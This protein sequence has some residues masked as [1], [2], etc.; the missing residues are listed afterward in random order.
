MT[1]AFLRRG[2]PGRI[3]SDQG[4]EFCASVSLNVTVISV[5]IHGMVIRYERDLIT[6]AR[7]LNSH[8]LCCPPAD[9]NGRADR[10]CWSNFLYYVPNFP[11]DTI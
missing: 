8:W 11:S 4:R 5:V 9:T 7:L 2:K 6:I 10:A 1:S 3:L